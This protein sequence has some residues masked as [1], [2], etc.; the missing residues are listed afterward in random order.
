MHHMEVERT[1]YLVRKVDPRIKREEVQ[2]VVKNC[3]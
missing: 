2:K 3:V 1:L